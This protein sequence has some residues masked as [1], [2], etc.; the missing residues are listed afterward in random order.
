MLEKNPDKRISSLEALNHP[1]FTSVLSSSPLVIRNSFDNKDLVNF[2]K[3]TLNNDMNPRSSR[4][5]NIGFLD[6][7]PNQ[8]EDMS[9]K[10][11][12]KETDKPSSKKSTRLLTPSVFGTDLPK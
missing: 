6:S 9:P 11:A 12:P 1:V 7:F 4:K 8:I 3:V 5:H 2:N 10:P